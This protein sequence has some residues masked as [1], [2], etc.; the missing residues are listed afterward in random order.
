MDTPEST[1]A[2]SLVVLRFS[3]LGD[4]AL[5]I[6]VLLAFSEAYPDVRIVLCT[7]PRFTPLFETLAHVDVISADLEGAH[8][9]LLGLYRLHKHLHKARPVCIVDLHNVLRTKVLKI[10]NGFRSTPFYV[11]DKGRSEKRE[12]IRSPQQV[13]RPLAHTTERYAEVFG[14]AGFP[15]QLQEH[16]I[17]QKRPIQDALLRRML[18]GQILIGIAPFAA[19]AAKSY[20]LEQMEE[21]IAWLNTKPNCKILVFGGGREEAQGVAPWEERYSNCLNLIGTYDFSEELNLISGLD[22]M[23]SMDSGNG[24]LSAIFG[25]PTLT[26]WGV[27]HP[28]AGFAPYSQPSSN[29]LLADRSRYPEIPTSVYGNRCPDGY[30]NAINTIPVSEIK[31]RINSVLGWNTGPNEPFGASEP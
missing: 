16:H 6:P 3:A 11:L 14:A 23:I 27:T 25:V 4:V 15:V 12:L 26:L 21:V 19:Y 28:Y 17:L 31:D 13:W 20:A 1:S 24:H 22:L 29:N 18:S 30:E 8:K 7:R 5:T 9:G 10:F 2:R